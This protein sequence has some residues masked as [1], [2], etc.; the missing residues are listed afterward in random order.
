MTR[1]RRAILEAL[2]ATRSH[3]TALELYELVRARL[4]GVNPATVYRNLEVL[5]ESGLVRRLDVPGAPRRFDGTV[6]DHWHVR[7]LRCGRLGDVEADVP[8]GAAPPAARAEGWEIVECSLEFLGFC[9]DCRDA[10][11]SERPTKEG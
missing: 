1:Q 8:S 5:A 7:C 2:A 6:E 4:P 9:P 10:G 3:P 11:G